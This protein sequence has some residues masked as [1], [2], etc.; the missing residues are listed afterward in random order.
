[1]QGSHDWQQTLAAGYKEDGY[2]SSQADPC[3]RWRRQNGK[4]TITST[5]GDDVLGGAEGDVEKKK[6]IEDLGKRWESSEVRSEILLG[7]K[8]TQDKKTGVITLL[9]KAYFTRM[10]EH[11]GLQNVKRRQTPLPPDNKLE[12][13]PNPLPDDE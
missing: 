3:V 4:Y 6:A 9:Q 11:F 1:M 7:M 10:L 5:Y 8:I 13:A 12:A 2:T